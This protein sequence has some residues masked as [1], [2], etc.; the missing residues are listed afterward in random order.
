MTQFIIGFVNVVYDI[1]L[2]LIY[3]CF[4]LFS[5]RAVR[6]SEH[7]TKYLYCSLKKKNI[8]LLY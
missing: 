1:D 6:M 7:F 5:T 4:V 3:A 2:M 8:I